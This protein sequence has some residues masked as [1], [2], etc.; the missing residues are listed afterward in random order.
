MTQSVVA[1]TQWQ[2]KVMTTRE[3]LRERQVETEWKVHWCM[4]PG[5]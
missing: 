1:E 5:A 2:R 3:T 4:N